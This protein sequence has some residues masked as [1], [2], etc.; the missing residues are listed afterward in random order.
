MRSVEPCVS[1]PRRDRIQFGGVEEID[2]LVE[3][4]IHLRVAFGLGVLLAPGH[5]AEADQA[6]IQVGTAETA[7]FH[8]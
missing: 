6:D 3:G 4:I 7:I 8:R 1:A 5:G 2:A